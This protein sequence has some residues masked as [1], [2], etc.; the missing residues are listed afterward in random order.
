MKIPIEGKISSLQYVKKSFAL[1]LE[2][3]YFFSLNFYVT[4]HETYLCLNK[5][6]IKVFPFRRTFSAKAI[7]Y[8]STLKCRKN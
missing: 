4:E 1:L 3:F 5:I 6:L 2:I 8:L 7:C